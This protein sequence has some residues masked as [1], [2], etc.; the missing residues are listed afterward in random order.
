MRQPQPIY[1]GPSGLIS[2]T[3]AILLATL[4]PAASAYTYSWDVGSFGE[5]VYCC[6]GSIYLY[7]TGAQYHHWVDGLAPGE[8]WSVLGSD[9][10]MAD[11]MI[12]GH[13][14]YGVGQL[15]WS[16]TGI[17]AGWNHTT[18]H[19][20]FS[21]TEAADVTIS[22]TNAP[23]I[24]L[25]GPNEEGGALGSD[26]MPAYTL[27]Q[28]ASLIGNNSLTHNFSNVANFMGMT[29]YDHSDAGT[30]HSVV[31]TYHLA[32]GDWSMWIG[33]NAGN[34]Q[35]TDAALGDIPFETYIDI[36]GN[37]QTHRIGY[38]SHGKNFQLTISTAPVPLPA[39]VWLFGSALAGLGVI[40]R[41][42]DR[43]A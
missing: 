11:P 29:Y 5:D 25:E 36:N 1:S 4:A 27:Y 16:G 37:P 35:N 15:S 2:A 43:R 13:T 28:G 33:G 7:T 21:L 30:A 19:V 22:L 14:F 6:N 17:N 32:A 8:T 18:Q 20:L 3:L 38:G 10:G 23:A 34:Q 39:A 31:E 41:R 26:L 42:R 9:H 40:G 12:Q 24:L